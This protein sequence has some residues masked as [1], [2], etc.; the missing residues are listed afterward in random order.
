MYY[1]KKTDQYL[2]L[3]TAA[4][5][6]VAFVGAVI[7]LGTSNKAQDFDLIDQPTLGSSSANV[8]IIIFQD[9][10]CD[11][12][13][14]FM[15]S[16]F[17][18][19]QEK[20]IKTNQVSF[21][22]IPIAFL[23]YSK[24]V[25]AAALC[26]Y[27]QNEN[28]FWPFIKAWYALLPTYKV[29]TNLASLLKSLSLVDQETLDGCRASDVIEKKMKTNLHIAEILLQTQVSVPSVLVN[30][31]KVEKLSLDNL[32]HAIDNALDRSSL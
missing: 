28:L 12:C 29:E 10:M 26:L 2:V 7:F 19:I 9:L 1:S 17:P 6:V 21:K 14:Y 15:Q 32:S 4:I 22:M 27:Q 25:T 5:F 30:G 8:Q 20:Y 3:V 23:P 31:K 24:E 16:I 13:K 11:D 18:T